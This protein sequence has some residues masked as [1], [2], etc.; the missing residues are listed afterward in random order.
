MS[1]DHTGLKRYPQDKRNATVHDV[2]WM[3]KFLA[4]IET[5]RELFEEVIGPLWDARR[6]TGRDR[7]VTGRARGPPQRLVLMH[8]P[9]NLR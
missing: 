9:N 3:R 6:G 4:T 5:H 1:S 2:E 7:G 8:L